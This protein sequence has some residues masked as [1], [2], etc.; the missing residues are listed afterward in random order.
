MTP[1]EGPAMKPVI[2]A[3][4]SARD[5]RS[6]QDVSQRVASAGLPFALGS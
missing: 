1:T 3:F 2:S 6:M 5:P 4:G